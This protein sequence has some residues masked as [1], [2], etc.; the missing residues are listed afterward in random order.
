MIWSAPLQIVLSLVFLYF[1]MGYAIFAGFVVMI[2]MIPINAA[3]AAKSR[4]YQVYMYIYTR[5]LYMHNI[6]TYMY[7]YIMYI[8]VY[9]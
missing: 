5:A 4:Q 1:T 9:I 2:L 6:I 8:H 7:M 3:L